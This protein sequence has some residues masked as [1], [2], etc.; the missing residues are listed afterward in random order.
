MAKR[1]TTERGYGSQHQTERA[2]W[3]PTVEAGEAYCQE[4]ICLM[5]DRWINPLEQ[6]DLAHGFDRGTY[7]GPAHS[8]CNRSEGS[9]RWHA[10]RRPRRRWTL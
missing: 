6:W 2:K 1:S 5:P 7:L 3:K 8:R 4:R 9:R 10:R